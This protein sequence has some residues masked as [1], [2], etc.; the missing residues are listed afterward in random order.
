MNLLTNIN[1]GHV[2]ILT[3]TRFLEK[4]LWLH[5][6]S[7]KIEAALCFV[8]DLPSNCLSVNLLLVGLHV[9]IGWLANLY[10]QIFPVKC[11]MLLLY[12]ANCK[13]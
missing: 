5:K 12:S 10:P 7:E 9:A 8:S 6:V 3:M 1:F 2:P 13:K 4:V 11:F